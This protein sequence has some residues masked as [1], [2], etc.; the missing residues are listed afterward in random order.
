MSASQRLK[1]AAGE[2]EIVSALKAAGWPHADRTSN[3]KAQNTRGD[4][5][6]GPQ[7]VHIE[8]KRQEKLNICSALDQA[9]SDANPLDVPIV[10]HRPSRHE[11][12]ATLKL[13]DLLTYLAAR[14]KQ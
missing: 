2:R 1:G 10:I 14:E 12:M 7:G 13:E 5:M 8:I 4:I 3:G 9:I 6:N 11:W